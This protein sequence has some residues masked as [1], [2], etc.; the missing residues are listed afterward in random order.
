MLARDDERSA[1]DELIGGARAGRAGALVLRGE[2]GMGKTT[3]LEYAAER[4][5]DFEVRRAAGVESESG[6]GFGSLQRLLA[7]F[8]DSLEELP[9]PQ[10]RALESRSASATARRR[11]DSSSASRRSH[12]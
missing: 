11:T 2:A 7:P 4:R 3:L 6:I 1:I 10:R 5:A 8:L 9:A 12:S